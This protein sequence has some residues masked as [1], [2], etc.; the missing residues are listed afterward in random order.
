MFS[1]IVEY[2]LMHRGDCI[3]FCE[4]CYFCLIRL[5]YGRV[6][7]AQTFIHASNLLPS[8]PQAHSPTY[9]MVVSN[10]K[11]KNLRPEITKLNSLQSAASEPKNAPLSLINVS[12]IWIISRC[13]TVS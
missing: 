1:L 9:Q 2:G 6:L 4:T 8:T 12:V 5:L 11:L 13:A 7:G 10:P 3:N